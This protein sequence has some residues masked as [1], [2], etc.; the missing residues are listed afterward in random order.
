MQNATRFTI[1]IILLLAA[2]VSTAQFFSLPERLP[3]GQYGNLLIRRIAGKNL[4]KAVSFSHWS[5]RMKYTCR[6]CHFEL[7]FEMNVNATEITEEK[8]RA[9][10][11]CGACHDGKTAF[12][13]TEENCRKCHNGRIAGNKAGFKA[14]ADFSKSPYGNGID[15]VQAV[16]QGF[17]DPRQSIMDEEYS[18][19]PFKK[20]FALDAGW[21]MIPPAFFSHEVHNRWLDCA[22]CH[23][24][25]FNVKKKTTEHFEMRYILEGKFCGACHLNVAFPLDDCKRCHPGMR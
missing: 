7:E 15:W 16:E 22:N 1:L 8:N 12:G 24:D 9:G 17:V 18:S 3:P 20:D 14:L 10:Q 19:M 6:V 13:H 21:A 23:P 11:F 25:I 4:R 5:H 2:G